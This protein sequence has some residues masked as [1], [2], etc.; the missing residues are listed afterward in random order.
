[1]TTEQ[2]SRCHGNFGWYD[3]SGQWEPC[4]DC[5]PSRPHEHVWMR[6]GVTVKGSTL[7]V[8]DVCECTAVR[9]ASGEVEEPAKPRTALLESRLRVGEYIE[10]HVAKFAHA[11]PKA[12]S[13]ELARV[14]A[15][16]AESGWNTYRRGVVL[17]LTRLLADLA[18]RA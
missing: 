2:C 16:V 1:M 14:T 5:D 15:H 11:G 9:F 12:L 4:P 8:F 13:D 18:E 6:R 10:Q 3:G 17:G 7:L